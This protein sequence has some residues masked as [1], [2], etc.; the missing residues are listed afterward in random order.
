MSDNFQ[1]GDRVRC[2]DDGDLDGK[3]PYTDAGAFLKKGKVY[4]VRE[5][6]PY[7]HDLMLERVKSSW[8]KRRFELVERPQPTP[9]PRFK[10]GDLLRVADISI[11]RD[12]I[13]Y[14]IGDVYPLRDYMPATNSEDHELYVRLDVNNGV[15]NRDMM[16]YEH[17]FELVTQPTEEDVTS[18]VRA[19]IA[20]CL[21][22]LD[23]VEED[24]Y[25][26]DRIEA[27]LIGL[28]DLLKE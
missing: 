26:L 6:S 16:H 3:F 25:A 21:E 22:Y 5:I 7:G 9:E 8:D 23:A 14:K 12:A 11:N 4:T 13:L 15:L 24:V 18:R 1:K 28:Q 20:R 27:V 2:I 19:D 10:S 17:R